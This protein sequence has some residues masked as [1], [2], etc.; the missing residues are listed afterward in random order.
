[1]RSGLVLVVVFALVS[2]PFESDG[3]EAVK[4]GDVRS[5]GGRFPPHAQRPLLERRAT[6]QASPRGLERWKA[7]VPADELPALEDPLRRG[8]HAPAHLRH[9]TAEAAQ[10][11]LGEAA[12]RWDHE[13]EFRHAH[14]FAHRSGR[15]GEK[16]V[17][18]ALRLNAGADGREDLDR[19]VDPQVVPSTPPC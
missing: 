13:T 17:R 5:R 7:T 15:R 3:P 12:G 19:A 1:M 6:A 16:T 14:G 11:K 4:L 8:V 18:R 2:V 9:R 10:P